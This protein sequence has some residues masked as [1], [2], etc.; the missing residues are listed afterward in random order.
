MFTKPSWHLWRYKW[1]N[2]KIKTQIHLRFDLS[3]VILT[4]PKY[5]MLCSEQLIAKLCSVFYPVWLAHETNTCFPFFPAAY[6]NFRHVIS[7]KNDNLPLSK[8]ANTKTNASYKILCTGYSLPVSR[9]CLSRCTITKE[10]FCISTVQNECF[11]LC[12]NGMSKAAIPRSSTVHSQYTRLAALIH[13]SAM[14]LVFQC[15]IAPN[16]NNKCTWC[17]WKYC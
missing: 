8:M 11:L 13:Q 6:K 5:K 1:H 16:T 3:N 14:L 15:I 17:T 9:K 7:T 2:C 10:Y 4:T 12:L